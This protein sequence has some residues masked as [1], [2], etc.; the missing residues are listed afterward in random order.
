MSPDPLMTN[1][2]IFQIRDVTTASAEVSSR[3][4]VQGMDDTCIEVSLKRAGKELPLLLHET[5]L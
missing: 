5:V 3:D 1:Q 2:L 4:D